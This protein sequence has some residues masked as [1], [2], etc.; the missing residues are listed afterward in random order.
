MRRSLSELLNSF[1]SKAGETY[2]TAPGGAGDALRR[3]RADLNVLRNEVNI[4]ANSLLNAP[5]KIYQQ[6]S[7]ASGEDYTSSY[8]AEPREQ[9]LRDYIGPEEYVN[10]GRAG[11]VIVKGEFHY[12]TKKTDDELLGELRRAFKLGSAFQQG[13]SSYI[14]KFTEHFKNGNGQD[15]TN[16][17]YLA[18]MM[19]HVPVYKSLISEIAD[20]FKRQMVQRRG[21][22]T[23]VNF[24][25]GKMLKYFPNNV[26]FGDNRIVN[27]LVGGV[28]EIKIYLTGIQY[29]HTPNGGSAISYRA[30][31]HIDIFDDFGVSEADTIKTAWATSMGRYAIISMWLLQHQ[32]G[33]KPFRTKFQF[34]LPIN[35]TF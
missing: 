13:S 28:Q 30:S 20:I 5:I 34:N 29:D 9:V 25:T 27:M 10:A 24:G 2:L 31:L 1:K 33:F 21:D 15:Y 17:I 3:Q 16:T 18:E 23:Y 7:S 32:R 26:S 4:K 14:D 6:G 19:L 11:R 22:F 8:N 35:G 12:L